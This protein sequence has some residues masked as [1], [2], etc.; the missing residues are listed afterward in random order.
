MD[1]TFYLLRHGESK[2]NFEKRHQGWMSGNP[3]TINGLIQAEKASIIFNNHDIDIIYSS[4]LLRTKQTARVIADK[5]KREISYSKNL[6][7]FRRSKA[8]EGLFVHEYI[9]ISEFKIWTEASKLDSNFALSDGESRAS[10]SS[11]V[12]KFIS[13]INDRFVKKNILLV[14]HTD[15]IKEII[16]HLTTKSINVESISN[17]SIIKVTPDQKHTIL[18]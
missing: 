6:L 4:P 12:N 8:Q 18:N 1:N 17:C 13:K 11:R 3:L 10:F 16:K 14:T 15:V 7:D 2:F 9:D 5:I